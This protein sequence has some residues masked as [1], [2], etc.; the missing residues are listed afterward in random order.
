[1]IAGTNPSVRARYNAYTRARMQTIYYVTYNIITIS[2]ETHTRTADIVRPTK[3][4][5]IIYNNIKEVQDSRLCV[6]G[7]RFYNITRYRCVIIII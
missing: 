7:R 5:I 3:M 2:Y 4:Y 1:M 6:D